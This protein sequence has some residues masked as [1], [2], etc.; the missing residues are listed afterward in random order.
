MAKRVTNEQTTNNT[1]R[2]S[3]MKMVRNISP[4][5]EEQSSKLFGFVTNGKKA[6]EN[7]PEA[8]LA[9]DARKTLAH[10]NL[11]LVL[12]I[13]NSYKVNEIMFDDLFQEGCKILCNTIDKFD[14]SKGFQ[15]STYAG[16]CIKHGMDDYF[17]KITNS[18]SMPRGV[19]AEIHKVNKAV[20]TLGITYSDDASLQK[21]ADAT[22]FS[23]NRVKEL[24]NSQ[25]SVAALDGDTDEEEK[26]NINEVVAD[27][28]NPSLDELVDEAMFSDKLREIYKF[29]DKREAS[30]LSMY[31][32]LEDNEEVKTRVIAEREHLSMQRVRQIVKNAT[33][34]L[35]N[36]PYARQLLMTC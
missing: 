29:L 35:R 28:S 22:G 1:S 13:A 6:L 33:E 24:L 20:D 26:P 7:S 3:I 11:R 17:N 14:P 21:V 30:I 15:F 4:L 31:Y 34:K 23:L 32:G 5:T 10:H 9:K 18:F 2:E 8:K 19:P 12:K 27:T 36:N 16:S 25:Y